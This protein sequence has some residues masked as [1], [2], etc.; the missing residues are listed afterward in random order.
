MGYA[1]GALHPEHDGKTVGGDAGVGEGT[2]LD[3]SGERLGWWLTSPSEFFSHALAVNSV[4]RPSAHRFDPRSFSSPKRPGIEIG[5][6]VRGSA[7]ST[8]GERSRTMPGCFPPPCVF[9][10][11]SV[12]PDDAHYGG[13]E[14][15]PPRRKAL[16]IRT[17]VARREHYRQM[18]KH[19]GNQES[20]TSQV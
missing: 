12:L 20:G 17:L 4:A 7:V 9:A 16:Q 8:C 14:A 3:G 15:I 13:R 1:D 19:Q 18:V 11:K 5:D 6:L 10:L 2:S